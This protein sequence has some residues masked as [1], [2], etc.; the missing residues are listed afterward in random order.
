ME[1]LLHEQVCRVT[2]GLQ[3]SP[4]NSGEA[5]AV[6]TQYRWGWQCYDE[7]GVVFNRCTADRKHGDSSKMQQWLATN[8]LMLW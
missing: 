4:K 3:V 8:E 1:V 6:C 7:S 5:R 2:T